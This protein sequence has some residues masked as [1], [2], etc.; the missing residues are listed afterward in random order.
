MFEIV[1]ITEIKLKL[2]F[3]AK[4]SENCWPVL[5]AKNFFLK[6]NFY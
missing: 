6:R 3:L 4:C 1:T 5:T 2:R